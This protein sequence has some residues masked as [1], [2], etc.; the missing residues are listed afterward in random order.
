VKSPCSAELSWVAP[1]GIVGPGLPGLR[2]FWWRYDSSV[3]RN[4]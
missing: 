2:N 4:N 3:D 1:R